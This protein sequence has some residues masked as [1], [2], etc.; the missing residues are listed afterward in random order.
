MVLKS[1]HIGGDHPHTDGDT[2]EP[3][4]EE[5]GDE[6]PQSVGVRWAE[7]DYH[8]EVHL[9]N[10]RHHHKRL[11]SDLHAEDRAG[12]HPWGH[13]DDVSIELFF[14]YTASE[15]VVKL[16]FFDRNVQLVAWLQISMS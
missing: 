6:R 1:L 14:T 11:H 12:R 15:K 9:D 10:L 2:E 5:D 3:L 7:N 16:Q 4:C 13:S 8:P